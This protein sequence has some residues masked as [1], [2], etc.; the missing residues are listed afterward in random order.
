MVNTRTTHN[1]AIILC[2]GGNYWLLAYWLPWRGSQDSLSYRLQSFSL[3]YPFVNIMG[4]TSSSMAFLIK[5]RALISPNSLLF[6]EATRVRVKV[7]KMVVVRGLFMSDL[8]DSRF[9]SLVI[10]EAVLPICRLLN[11]VGNRTS[12]GI[13]ITVDVML[14][15]VL[16]R[17]AFR[18]FRF[19]GHICQFNAG[20]LFR[21]LVRCLPRFQRAY[22]SRCN[23][24]V[25]VDLL[26][27]TRI[28]FTPTRFLLRRSND[29]SVTRQG[30]D[31]TFPRS[32]VRVFF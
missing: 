20:S 16:K 26:R 30:V 4:R 14:S 22:V 24:S 9:L 21:I 13:P 17:A 18:G 2:W 31:L 23:R 7:V 10:N 32:N 29:T 12:C 8:R 15:S 27:S 5:S 19:L 25:L 6:H 28:I 3:C 11:G 1:I